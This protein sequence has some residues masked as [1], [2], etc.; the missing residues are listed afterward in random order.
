M[1]QH[2]DTPARPTEAQLARGL[3]LE[4][5]APTLAPAGDGPRRFRG[6]AYTGAALSYYGYLM[7]VDLAGARL[8][9]PCPVLEGHNRNQRRGVATLSSDGRAL[10]IEGTLL[11]NDGARAIAADADDGFP[12]QLSVHAQPQGVEELA[13]GTTAEVNGRTV[14]GPIDILRRVSIREVSFTPTG[15]DAGTS[16]EMLSLSII[17]DA[18][19]ALA[20]PTED[21]DMP[22][23][24][25]GTPAPAGTPPA[26]DPDLAA[27]VA[28]LTAELSAAT[29]RA[30]QAEAR[31]AAVPG[32]DVLADL[33]RQ[34]SEQGAAI[35]QRDRDDLILAAEA[36]GRLLPGSKLH[37]HAAALPL[38]PLRALLSSLTPIPALTGS[39][40]RGRAPAGAGSTSAE[41]WGPELE[42][43]FGSKEVY[44]A[45]QAAQARGLVKIY[46]G[47][48]A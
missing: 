3:R 20:V 36:D 48:Q 16:A 9:S 14:T 11:G 46:G 28:A 40:T 13:T 10:A 42:A 22:Q 24:S 39:Q 43:E 12:W 4:A 29:A 32:T 17:P 31:L 41:T 26:T 30:E 21:I 2:T 47:D 27:R 37:E 8:P 7:I 35:A 19:A 15:V 38:E 34:V 44:E 45:Y 6:T 33:Q 18:G 23:Q 25:A 5:P 1:S